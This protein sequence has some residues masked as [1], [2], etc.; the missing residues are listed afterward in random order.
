[1]TPDRIRMMYTI[2][3]ARA[4]RNVLV[5]QDEEAGTVMYEEQVRTEASWVVIG[6]RKTMTLDEWKQKLQTYPD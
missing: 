4:L 5:S 2:G 3:T 1:M 6:E